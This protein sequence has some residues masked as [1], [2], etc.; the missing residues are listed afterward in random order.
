MNIKE[1]K[2]KEWNSIKWNL[3]SK[4]FTFW[5]C[6]SISRTGESSICIHGGALTVCFDITSGETHIHNKISKRS[7]ASVEVDKLV[8]LK[9]R[10]KQWAEENLGVCYDEE[11]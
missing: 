3:E 6:S 4:L 5:Y 7:G 1:M 9:N 2:N 11:V 10:L 8:E